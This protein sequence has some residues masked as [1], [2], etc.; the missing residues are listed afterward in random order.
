ML[1]VFFWNMINISSAKKELPDPLITNLSSNS[2]QL[3]QP[4]PPPSVP[5]LK[6]SSNNNNKNFFPS[7]AIHVTHGVLLYDSHLSWITRIE[8]QS[9]PL[10]AHP[11]TLP[12]SFSS[13]LHLKRYSSLKTMTLGSLYKVRTTYFLEIQ[14]IALNTWRCYNLEE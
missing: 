6:N 7:Q 5:S 8:E 3:S 13:K 14:P 11:I 12:A 1:G 9:C 4:P 2:S 10:Q